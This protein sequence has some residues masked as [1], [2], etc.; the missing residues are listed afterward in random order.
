MIK[1]IVIL[2]S[3][4]SIGKNLISLIKKDKK[5]F[6]IKLLST[7]TNLNLVVK[8]A[9]EFK[10]KHIII[11]NKKYFSIAKKKYKNLD[12]K[13][14]NSFLVIKKIFN[15]KMVDY[16][17]ISIVGLDGLAP[18]LEMIKFSKSIAIAN[19]ESIICGWNLIKKKIK[20]YNTKFIP[21][22]SEH[23]S[24]YSLLN[25]N[26]TNTIDKIFI[27]ASGGPFLN[28][29]KSKL[30]NVKKSHAISHPNWNMGQKIS[31]DSSTMMNKVF[32]VLEAKKIFDI[33]LKNIFILTHPKSY[34]HSI[35]KFKNEIIKIL[36]HEPDMKIPIYNSLFENDSKILKSNNLNLNIL[37]NLNL[38]SI[39][40]TKFPLVKILKHFKNIDSLYETALVTINDFFVMK[41]LNDEIKYHEMIK[42]IYK[43]ANLKY[44]LKYRYVIPKNVKDIYNFRDYVSMKINDLDV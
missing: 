2:G 6:E 10:V 4:G 3:T 13:F 33:K 14:H 29:Q 12:I 24:I 30:L 41:Y 19:K 37:N 34:I 42:K 43:Y 5:N 40:Y 8:Q 25:N 11:S 27:T 21:V 44:F 26:K 7:H 17:M 31:I 32:E 16:S 15:K 20:N 1:K 39:N 35:V 9:I 23:F 28:Q 36:I 22:D 38:K 18:T